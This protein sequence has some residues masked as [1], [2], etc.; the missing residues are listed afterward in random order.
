MDNTAQYRHGVLIGNWNEDK[1]G[2][3]LSTQQGPNVNK[4]LMYESV[5][6]ASYRGGSKEAINEYYEQKVRP[7]GDKGLPAD[8]LFPHN[9]ADTQE[10]RYQTTYNNTWNT[11]KGVPVNDPSLRLNLYAK[12]KAQWEK[13]KSE[14]SRVRSYATEYSTTQTSGAST[15]A[16]PIQNNPYIRQGVLE[17]T[18]DSPHQQLRLRTE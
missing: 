1:F 9:G 4:D 12:K 15:M 7:D 2:C 5:M 10:T 6:R 17:R 14:C 13:E 18:F 3:Q 8:L 11:T 16:L